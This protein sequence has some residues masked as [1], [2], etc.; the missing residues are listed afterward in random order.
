MR[1]YAVPSNNIT[2]GQDGGGNAYSHFPGAQPSASVGLRCLGWIGG[3]TSTASGST[4]QWL[5]RFDQSAGTG[6]TPEPLNTLAP[7]AAA[8]ALTG[9]GGTDE[10]TAQVGNPYVVLGQ[11]IA[12][13]AETLFRGWT[14]PKW[15]AAPFLKP[16]QAD[17]IGILANDPTALA[18]G[19]FT[20]WFSEDGA[21]GAQYIRGRRYTA[22]PGTAAFN[23]RNNKAGL[24]GSSATTRDKGPRSYQ[25]EINYLNAA[26]WP[27]PSPNPAAQLNLLLNAVTA[28]TLTA[29]PGTYSI[30]GSAANLISAR[31]IAADPGVYTIT[32]SDAA[33]KKGFT[34]LADFGVYTVTGS[35]AGL[36][37]AS[38]IAADPGVYTLVGSNANLLRAL[39]LLADSGVY[40]I[41]GSDATFRRT[42]IMTA[43]SGVYVIT[44]SAANLIYTPTGGAP[45][46]PRRLMLK[47]GL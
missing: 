15:N 39:R 18:T 30:V 6:I 37:K 22:R 12:N 9:A 5:T 13:A 31:K 46:R 34:L 14:P 36:L 16:N 27:T 28:F 4:R 29:D 11:P 41:A 26:C 10:G 2:A 47:V 25:S 19:T 43:N 3:I 24:E 7:A 32:G 23:I 8:S 20:L 40:S 44:G 42:Y 35:N 17:Y 1:G 38:R 45:A 33:L 21:Y